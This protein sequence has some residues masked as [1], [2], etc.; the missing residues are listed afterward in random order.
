M[1]V[2]SSLINVTND[3]MIWLST[4]SVHF[5]LIGD[6]LQ[7]DFCF[8]V[9]CKKKMITRKDNSNKEYFLILCNEGTI[10]WKH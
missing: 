1:S 8:H 2:V 4:L 5:W 3:A 9:Q 7:V 10:I 6:N